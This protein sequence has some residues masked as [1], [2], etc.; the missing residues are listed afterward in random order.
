MVTH[1]ERCQE[2]K[3]GGKIRANASLRKASVR[4]KIQGRADVDVKAEDS[5]KGDE[6]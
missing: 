5:G 6:Q 1:G 4:A 3:A 2:C